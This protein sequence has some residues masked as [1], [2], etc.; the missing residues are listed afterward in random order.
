VQH[1]Y[2]KAIYRQRN[3]VERMFCHIKDWRRIP[4]LRADR[5]RRP[6]RRPVLIGSDGGRARSDIVDPS[7]HG[8]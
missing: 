3:I 8:G 7:L 2:D 1:D 4:R 6:Q 5:G